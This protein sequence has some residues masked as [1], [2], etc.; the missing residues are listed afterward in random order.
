M[1]ERVTVVTL[2]VTLSLCVSLFDFGEG[3]VFRVETYID[4]CEMSFLKIEAIL[5]K[6]RVEKL[7]FALF[8]RWFLPFG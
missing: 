8:L 2:S 4:T 1:R 3:A 6:K 5:E 7:S